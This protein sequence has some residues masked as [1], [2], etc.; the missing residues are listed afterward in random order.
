MLS[1]V[2][3]IHCTLKGKKEITNDLETEITEKN[4][5]AENSKYGAI[6]VKPKF[7]WR[8]EERMK[9][10]NNLNTGSIAAVLTALDNTGEVDINDLCSHVVNIMEESAMKCGFKIEPNDTKR[11]HCTQSKPWYNETCKEKRKVYTRA[12]NHYMNARNNPN[13]EYMKRACK[14]YKKELRK[15]AANIK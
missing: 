1:D 11:K 6:K 14:D 13:Q 3:C 7:V 10:V 8:E 5:N 4:V 12:R 15:A 9:F 2:H